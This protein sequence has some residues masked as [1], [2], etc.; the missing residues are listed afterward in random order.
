MGYVILFTL[1]AL[2]I[3][4]VCGILAVFKA[5]QNYYTKVQRDFEAG[6]QE[7]LEQMWLHINPE[8]LIMAKVV[9]ALVPGVFLF[10]LMTLG[11]SPFM[12]RILFG[13]VVALMGY[14]VPDKYLR[15]KY[16]RW[17]DKIN[18]QLIDALSV[19]S[20]A[21]RSGMSFPQ[22]MDILV[23][24]MDEPISVEFTQIIQDTR[25]GKNM[26]EALGELS[27]RVPIEDV[28]IMVSAITIVRQ[29]GGN[30]AEV[31]D[32][33][34]LT[35]RE[36]FKIEGKIKSLTST[37]KMQ[38]LMVCSLPLFIATAMFVIDQMLISKM[39]QTWTGLGL[40]V[41]MFTLQTLGYIVINWICNIDI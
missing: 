25:L 4:S 31:F 41:I 21:L 38:A 28:N 33:L 10:L 36:R 5:T 19:M 35:V 8:T 29:S 11:Q 26:D 6:T 37:G 34:S 32:K 12:A 17:K 2:F 14:F 15:W 1:I 24:E 9:C 30:L 3:A 23:R 18:E 13:A 40:L 16:E 39:W 27:D 20:N 22:A 7:K